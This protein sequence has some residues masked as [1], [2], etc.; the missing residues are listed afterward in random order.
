MS[1]GSTLW[2]TSHSQA[3]G[4]HDACAAVDRSRGQG[5][6]RRCCCMSG[7]RCFKK[8]DPPSNGLWPGVVFGFSGELVDLAALGCAAA[9]LAPEF[10]RF[11]CTVY[12]RNVSMA[13]KHTARTAAMTTPSTLDISEAAS[14]I[15]L[16]I[17]SVLYG[18]VQ[19]VLLGPVTTKYMAI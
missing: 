13:V 10:V 5:M 4:S 3:R 6:R 1:G 2:R 19:E 9:A 12:A 8:A 17:S 15:A 18:E 14:A 7:C 16:K 11:C